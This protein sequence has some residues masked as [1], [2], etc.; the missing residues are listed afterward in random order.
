MGQAGKEAQLDQ[1]CFSWV[2]RCELVPGLAPRHVIQL[3]LVILPFNRRNFDDLSFTASLQV[4]S[5]TRLFNQNSSHGLSRGGK[6]MPA[7]VPGLLPLDV[8][9]PQIRLMHERSRL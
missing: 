3:R 2:F 6:E 9:Q 8:Y 5:A 7:A 4:L 1:L